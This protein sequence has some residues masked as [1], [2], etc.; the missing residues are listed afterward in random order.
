MFLGD[1]GTNSCI[2][3]TAKG[4]DDYTG[5]ACYNFQGPSVG[6]YSCIDYAACYQ[7]Y[8][9][10]YGGT[11]GHNSC[12]GPYSCNWID[13]RDIDD[14]SCNGIYACAYMSS[15]Y[16]FSFELKTWK[17]KNNS[18]SSGYF[19]YHAQK[20]W[21]MVVGMLESSSLPTFDAKSTIVSQSCHI[22]L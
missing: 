4:R 11:I 9:R 7:Y 3:G 2:G 13:N 22:F 8:S 10:Y 5:Y 18:N 14:R 16:K 21:D 20:M 15:K 12:N 17:T 1:V 19:Y 6:D